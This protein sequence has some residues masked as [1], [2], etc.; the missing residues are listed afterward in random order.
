VNKKKQCVK[1]LLFKQNVFQQHI[2]TTSNDFINLL[3]IMYYVSQSDKKKHTKVQYSTNIKTRA[4]SH[5]D[6]LL[7]KFVKWCVRFL[8][9]M[10]PVIS[11]HPTHI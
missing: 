6:A 8:L 4:V 11:E 9:S 7:Q 3:Q 5:T 10:S 1:E 2:M